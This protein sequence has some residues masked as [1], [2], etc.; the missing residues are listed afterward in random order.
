MNSPQLGS[1][2]FRMCVFFALNPHEELNT[3]DVLA[4]FW[5]DKPL[6]RSAQDMRHAVQNSVK[7]GWLARESRRGRG[8]Q[9]TYSAGPKLLK[10]VGWIE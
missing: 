5:G 3:S 2:A 6:R 9:N 1:V 7:N 8:H 4:K 10:E